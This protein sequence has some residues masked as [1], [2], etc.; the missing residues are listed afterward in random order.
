MGGRGTTLARGRKAAGVIV[1]VEGE[2][3]A[4]LNEERMRGAGVVVDGGLIFFSGGLL[5]F[6]ETAK[7]VLFAAGVCIVGSVIHGRVGRA[8]GVWNR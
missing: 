1:V 2:D 5:L 7:R 6:R 3:V 8:V 4:G